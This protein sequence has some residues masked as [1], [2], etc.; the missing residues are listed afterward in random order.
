M[1]IMAWPSSATRS[2]SQSRLMSA[3]T[4]SPHY[5][6]NHRA[7]ARVR[8][9]THDTHAPRS[10]G[11]PIHSAHPAR[12]QQFAPRLPDRP[13][14]PTGEE[15]RE[16]LRAPANQG[17]RVAEVVALRTSSSSVRGAHSRD[18]QMVSVVGRQ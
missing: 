11:P 13:S 16:G 7:L 4:F 5:S 17:G 18:R 14:L 8:H 9:D 3:T 10:V 12:W 15:G 6:S 1:L 2:L